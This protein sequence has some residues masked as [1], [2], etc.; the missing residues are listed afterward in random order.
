MILPQ[1]AQT[2]SKMSLATDSSSKWSEDPVNDFEPE[3]RWIGHAPD[4]RIDS[5]TFIG[6][7]FVQCS[8]VF[9]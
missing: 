4:D 7:I 5:N 8:I 1:R 9:Y 2:I 6:G 3:S